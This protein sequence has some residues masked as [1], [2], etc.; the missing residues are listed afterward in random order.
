LISLITIPFTEALDADVEWDAASVLL[1]AAQWVLA[2]VSVK[3]LD[4]V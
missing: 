3:W 2:W 4:L 1:L